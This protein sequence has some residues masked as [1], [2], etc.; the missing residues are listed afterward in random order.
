[1]IGRRIDLFRYSRVVKVPD[2]VRNLGRED[3]V[4]NSIFG[5]L[6]MRMRA[7]KV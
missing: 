1:L 4:K 6:E 3:E 5:E 7:S 2:F